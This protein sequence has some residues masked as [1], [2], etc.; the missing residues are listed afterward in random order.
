MPDAT[1]TTIE[2]PP[3]KANTAGT[4]AVGTTSFGSILVGLCLYYF[5]PDTPPHIAG[6]WDALVNGVFVGGSVWLATYF[7]PH[8]AIVK[9]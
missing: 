8:G 6:M 1:T 3:N 4:V 9:E 2:V 5:A 7:T